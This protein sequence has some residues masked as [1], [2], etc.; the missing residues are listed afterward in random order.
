[1]WNVLNAN[2]CASCYYRNDTLLQR[3]LQQRQN[4]LK[5]MYSICVVSLL[6]CSDKYVSRNS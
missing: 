5:R 2:S 4:V 3:G 1:M 6:L